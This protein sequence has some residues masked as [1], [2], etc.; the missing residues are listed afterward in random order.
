MDLA[1]GEEGLVAT[2]TIRMSNG[3]ATLGLTS[4]D[5]RDWEENR[6]LAGPNYK[7]AAGRGV[8]VA[9]GSDGTFTSQDGN[10]WTKQDGVP[11]GAAKIRYTCGRF[12]VLGS[13]SVIDSVR[14][15]PQVSHST[16]G[17]VW[18][19]STVTSANSLVDA[20]SDGIQIVAI[21]GAFREFLVSDDR[22]E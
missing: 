17:K 14:S 9:A 19:M 13:T 18:K 7:V 20:A 6:S 12:I 3:D 2:S 8:F 15:N 16:S 5:G 4:K 22:L 11:P 21:D 1:A 10:A